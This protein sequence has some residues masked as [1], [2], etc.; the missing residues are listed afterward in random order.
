MVLVT[1]T[2][3]LVAAELNVENARLRQLL[4]GQNKTAGYF[5]ITNNG[6]AAVVL[7]GASS[8]AADVIEIH[9]TT[10]DGNVARM[11][12]VKEVVI[13]PAETVRFEPGGL[14]LMLYRISVLADLTQIQLLTTSGE[15]IDAAF[16][17]VPVGVE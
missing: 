9:R 3:P 13:A 10:R 2:S 11:R 8:D 7:I 4:P 14:H 5:D 12:R 15:Q 16:R 17:Q 1:M 6:L